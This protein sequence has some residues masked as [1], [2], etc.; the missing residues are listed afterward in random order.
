MNRDD[1]L[2]KIP[3]GTRDA[4]E[5]IIERFEFLIN[6][7]ISLSAFLFKMHIGTT[8][9]IPTGVGPIVA[10]GTGAFDVALGTSGVQVGLDLGFGIGVDFSVGPFSASASYTQS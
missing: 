8:I 3:S 1:L 4:V 2:E 7:T 9:K 10:L 6:A 5:R